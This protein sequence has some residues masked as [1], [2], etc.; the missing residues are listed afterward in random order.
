MSRWPVALLALCAAAIGTFMFL[1]YLRGERRSALLIGCHLLL[2]ASALEPLLFVLGADP[3]ARLGRIAAL[4]LGAALF[5]ALTSA[6]LRS[7]R[8][9]AA[10]PVFYAHVASGAAGALMLLAWAIIP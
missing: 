7:N 4:L 5:A 8:A 2:A 9:A 3:A 6:V 10:T 1:Q